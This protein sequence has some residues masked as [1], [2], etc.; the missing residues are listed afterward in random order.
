MWWIP[1][2][3]RL[4]ALLQ[5]EYGDVRAVLMKATRNETEHDRVLFAI[6]YCLTTKG[7]EAQ[8]AEWERL[9]S[10][11]EMTQAERLKQKVFNDIL[12]MDE[13]QRK[14]KLS[15]LKFFMTQGQAANAPAKKKS[16]KDKQNEALESRIM[17]ELSVITERMSA[18]AST[19]LAEDGDEEAEECQEA[20]DNE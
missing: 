18:P 20:D 16:V 12:K 19:E 6:N 8:L 7:N 11:Y 13:T 1:D 4:V 17:Q 3:D 10:L 2:A 5:K 15:D 14:T 9:K